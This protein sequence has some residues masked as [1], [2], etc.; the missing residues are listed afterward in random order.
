MNA[1]RRLGLPVYFWLFVIYLFA[2]I[3]VMAAMGLRDSNFVAFPITKWT[4]HWYADVL[5]DREIL[6][7]L[8]LSAEV[9]VLSTLLSLV[10]GLPTAML[11][12]RTRGVLRGVL[13]ALVILPAFLPVVVSAIA[14]RMFI[15]RLGLEPGTAAIV[16]G[17]AVG[18]TPF[19]V[20]MVLTRLESMGRNVA[21]AARDLGA[22]EI[23]VFLRVVLPYLGPA[24]FGAFMFC[25]LLSF[26]DFV[27]SFFLS[28]FNP[29]FP[30][31]LF[32][33]LRFGLDPGI[34]AISTLVLL[35]SIALGLYA[36]QFSRR[37]RLRIDGE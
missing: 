20:V 8:W 30:V 10:I 14:L 5:V 16:F 37:R 24:L 25:L 36:E 9:A 32:A 13:L 19:V 21:D 12:A 11:V 2:P 26:E 34:A 23:I 29:T 31:L 22:D 35:V 18:S 28:S 7:S 15:G 4:T 17:H 6:G 3:V 1:I 27:R 33:K